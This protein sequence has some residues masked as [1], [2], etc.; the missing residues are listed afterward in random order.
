[1]SGFEVRDLSV[2]L[3]GRQVLRSICFDAE[4]G[5]L[6]ALVGPS[7]AGKTTLLRALAGLIP[8][9]G[10][11]VFAGVDVRGLS[12]AQ[13]AQKF[14][15]VPQ[16]DSVHWPLPVRD[17]VALGRFP[18]GASRPDRLSGRDLLAVEQALDVVDLQAMADRPVTKLSG[19][20]RRRVAVAR[21]LATQAP[22]LFADE[23][24]ASVDPHYQLSIMALLRHQ[25]REG[26]LV[27]VVTHDLGAAARFADRVLL[28]SDGRLE[29][30]GTPDAVLSSA[31]LADVFAID[32]FRCEHASEPVIV[33]WT[34]R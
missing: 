17:V 9:E 15:Y 27:F 5:S 8:S 11:M 16:D 22:V 24:T 2:R 12:V 13:R 26:A 33:P 10:G 6:V 14:A 21:A 30:A 20:E 4:N 32:I 18:H 19:G 23:P 3:A 29:A 25:A 1:M 7:G 34:A 28:L 31:Q